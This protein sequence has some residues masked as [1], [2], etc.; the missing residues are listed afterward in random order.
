MTQKKKKEKKLGRPPMS[1]K[2]ERKNSRTVSIL[3]STEKTAKNTF[4][5]LGKAIEA[6]IQM[7]QEIKQQT[8]SMNA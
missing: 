8:A 1:A 2:K 5:T 7:E 4:G 3:P 6:A